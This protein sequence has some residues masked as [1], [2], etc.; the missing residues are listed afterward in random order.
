MRLTII[1]LDFGDSLN[2]LACL[3]RC[4][5]HSR[6]FFIRTSN[7]PNLITISTLFYVLLQSILIFKCYLNNIRDVFLH[8][9]RFKNC[10]ISR[11][12]IFIDQWL[13]SS[14][15]FKFRTGY[16]KDM[17]LPITIKSVLHAIKRN[18]VGITKTSGYGTQSTQS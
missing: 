3:G 10:C 11:I 13:H 7:T 17:V 2:S 14:L 6:S 5:K 8:C 18:H 12:P 1:S 15:Q 4:I 9:K 16:L